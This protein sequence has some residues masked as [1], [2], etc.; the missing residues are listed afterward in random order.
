MNYN[1]ATLPSGLRVVHL[2][3]VSPVVWCGYQVAA[4]TRDEQPGEEGIAHLCEHMTFKGT[5]RR[6]A[7]QIANALECVG[8]ELNA[9]TTKED[10]TFYAAISHEHLRRAVDVL[11]DM[12]FCSSF[13]QPELDREIEVVCDE[14]ESYNDSPSELIYD[15]FENLLFAGHPLG[16][17]VLGQAS[18][19]RTYR[20]ED[21]CRFTARYYHPQNAIFFAYGDVD[22]SRLTDMLERSLGSCHTLFSPFKPAEPRQDELTASTIVRQ[23][24]THQTHIIIGTR[25]YAYKDERRATLSLLNNVLGGPA[26]NARLNQSLR[27]RHGLVYTVEGICVSY[28]DTGVWSIYFGCDAADS[29]RCRKLVRRELNRLMEKPLSNAQLSAAKRQM[30]GQIAIAGDNREQAALDFGKLFLHYG[31]LR[32]TSQ[33][34]SRIDAVTAADI[35]QVACQLFTPERLTTLIFQ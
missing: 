24:D 26:M 32:D 22:F 20:Q 28:S 9:F 14:I 11:T 8:G 34:L 3:S 6:S 30:K 33:L 4:G 35:Q 31:E 15:E 7:L 29:E 19:L 2:P 13:P 16:H 21:L 1:T 25:A 23:R 12:V 10:T 27:E 18:Q 17:N 5:A